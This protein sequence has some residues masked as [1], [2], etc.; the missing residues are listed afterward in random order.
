MNMETIF[1]IKR[2]REHDKDAFCKLMDIH[3]KRFI[4]LLKNIVCRSNCITGKD[5]K[6]KKYRKCCHCH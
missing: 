2:A 4:L 6:S 5:T 3:L 1:L